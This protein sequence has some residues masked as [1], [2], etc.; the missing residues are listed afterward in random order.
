MPQAPEHQHLSMRP[1]ERPAKKSRDIPGAKPGNDHRER[2]REKPE[3]KPILV[4]LQGSK[5]GWK[6]RGWRRKDNAWQ[7]AFHE[8]AGASKSLAWLPIILMLLV[9]IGLGGGGYWL[10]ARHQ[11]AQ[12]YLSPFVLDPILDPLSQSS[13]P[14]AKEEAV[15]EQYRKF[16]Q[17]FGAVEKG[18][19]EY[20]FKEIPGGKTFLVTYVEAKKKNEADRIGQDPSLAY[21][22]NQAETFQAKDQISYL[23]Y[24]ISKGD[25]KA[26]RTFYEDFVAAFTHEDGTMCK[27]LDAYGKA[28]QPADE[29]S[30]PLALDFMGALAE[31]DA[32]LSD[33]FYGQE[34]HRWAEAWLPSFAAETLPMTG[35]I[36]A[37]RISHPL[38]SSEP[39]PSPLQMIP[40]S[41]P[42]NYLPLTDLNLLALHNLTRQNPAWQDIYHK[43][44]DLVAHAYMNDF[45]FFAPGYLYPQANIPKAQYLTVAGTAYAVETRTQAQLCWQIFQD[46]SSPEAIAS[47]GQIL[48]YFSALV[49]QTGTLYEKYHMTMGTAMSEREDFLAACFFR[50]AAYANNELFACQDF[51]RF[52]TR[53]FRQEKWDPLRFT[54]A[55]EGNKG[56]SRALVSDQLEALLSGYPGP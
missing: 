29:R 47:A 5:A 18:L 50:K 34:L 2:S 21:E 32:A 52:L 46:R 24:C 54:F 7:E 23:R 37:G 3:E 28:T 26:T 8:D 27:A 51:D 30:W 15:A 33:P 42:L 43:Y 9:L 53:F 36:Q 35:Q 10:W 25:A 56:I 22:L 55:T 4:E 12:R 49:H 20:F 41:Q 31:A 11:A 40:V 17:E 19:R 44:R 1:G 38:T 14:Q 39:Q 13:R 6:T 48:H 45:S 16:N